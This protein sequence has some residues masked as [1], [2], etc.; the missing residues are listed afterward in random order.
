MI[1]TSTRTATFRRALPSAAI[2]AASF[3]LLLSSTVCA[4]PT[5]PTSACSIRSRRIG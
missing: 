3:C 5:S 4:P 1:M 2:L